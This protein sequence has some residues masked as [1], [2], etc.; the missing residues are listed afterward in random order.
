MW[1]YSGRYFTKKRGIE[2]LFLQYYIVLY[3][4]IYSMVQSPSWEANWFAASQKF[5]RI[6]RKPKVYL[7]KSL[8][9]NTYLLKSDRNMSGNLLEELTTFCFCPGTS[10]QFAIKSFSCSSRH[11]LVSKQT[12]AQQHT[13]KALLHFQPTAIRLKCRS[14]TSYYIIYFFFGYKIVKFSIE[15]IV[16]F[17]LIFT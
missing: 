4:L 9:D 2:I 11:F 17:C 15:L 16:I 6:S 5:P 7:G 10:H 3:L 1:P 14:V 12:I 13:R 8:Q